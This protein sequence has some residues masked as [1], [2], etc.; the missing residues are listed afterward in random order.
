MSSQKKTRFMGNGK[1][2]P[3]EVNGV[4]KYKKNIQVIECK[5]TGKTTGSKFKAPEKKSWGNFSKQRRR[6][7]TK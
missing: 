6:K 4:D 3:I 1:N 7:P 5:K 2:Y